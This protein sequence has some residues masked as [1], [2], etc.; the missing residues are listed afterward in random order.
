MLKRVFRAVL[1]TASLA[2]VCV[3]P[4]GASHNSDNKPITYCSEPACY[5]SDS[6]ESL[7]QVGSSTAY[8]SARGGNDDI[9]PIRAG[10]YFHY[11]YGG[12]GNDDIDGS[13][14]ADRAYGGQD[15]DQIYGD[16]G[17]DELYAGCE[18]GCSGSPGEN[19]LSGNSGNDT[20]GAENGHA[21][22]VYGGNNWDICYVDEALDVYTSACEDVR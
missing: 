6:S 1:F 20:L 21:D 22:V 13:V 3:L 9:D 16:D 5:G 12:N 2:A 7:I 11:L 17:P 8:F 15:D 14:G 10:N 18:G 4:A 19:L